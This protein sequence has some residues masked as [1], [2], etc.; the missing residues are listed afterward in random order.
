MNDN[1][2][3]YMNGFPSPYDIGV[4]VEKTLV[5][6]LKKHLKPGLFVI[7]P[8]YQWLCAS[9]DGYYDPLDIPLEVKYNIAKKPL[10]NVI[11]KHY[12]QLQYI[13]YCC[14]KENILLLVFDDKE[15]IPLIVDIDWHFIHMTLLKLRV[16]F[17]EHMFKEQNYCHKKCDYPYKLVP[18][19]IEDKPPRRVKRS[20]SYKRCR[21]EDI[22]VNHKR[23]HNSI[24]RNLRRVVKSTKKKL[25]RFK[26]LRAMK[27]YKMRTRRSKM[28]IKYKGLEVWWGED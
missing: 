20:Y 5:E 1:F 26:R 19:P 24:V 9:L 21:F 16:A 28:Q 14:E 15:I 11:A 27:K 17:I 4:L 10:E 23:N 2:L 22:F 6:S 25:L 18:L 8:Q 3:N 13:M 12:H 7:H